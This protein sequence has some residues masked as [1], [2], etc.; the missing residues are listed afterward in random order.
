LQFDRLREKNESA[1]HFDNFDKYIPAR[2]AIK[3]Y[4]RC[5]QGSQE[6]RSVRSPDSSAA[7]FGNDISIQQGQ[8]IRQIT[9]DSSFNLYARPKSRHF[10]LLLQTALRL[11]AE[12][13]R[14]SISIPFISFRFLGRWRRVWSE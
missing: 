12:N 7:R 4:F 13:S 2:P 6:W 14:P 3:I 11:H 10:C 9:T 8:V 5:N 1:E